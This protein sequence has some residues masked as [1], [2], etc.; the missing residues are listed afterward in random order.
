M[1]SFGLL[2]NE[3][4]GGYVRY[5]VSERLSYV[6]VVAAGRQTVSAIA[7]LEAVAAAVRRVIAE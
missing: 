5:S 3:T 2:R 1:L 4:A 6:A 7:S